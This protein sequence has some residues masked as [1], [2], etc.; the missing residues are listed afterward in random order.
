MTA[1]ARPGATPRAATGAARH[2]GHDALRHRV[3][4]LVS[5]SSDGEVATEEI[6]NA[7]GSLTAVG[8]TSL[9]FLRLIDALE[10]DFGIVL[11][12]DGPV[13]MLDDFDDLVRHLAEQG[14]GRGDG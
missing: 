10:E 11:D 14:A 9:T 3:A 4:A 5:R 12:L 2:R 6:L 8:V 13:L 7:G 1:A